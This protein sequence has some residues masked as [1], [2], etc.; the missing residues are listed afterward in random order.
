MFPNNEDE[1]IPAENVWFQQ[2]GAPPHFGIE[3]R[4]LLDD[5]FTG[6]WIGRRGPIEWPPRL[7]GFNPLKLFSFGV[8]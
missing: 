6:R 1:D 7:H 3:V 5:T 4:Q 8:S 2:D